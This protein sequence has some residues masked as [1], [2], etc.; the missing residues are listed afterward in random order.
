MDTELL[1]T[2][3]EVHKTSHF[4]HAADNLFLTQAAVSARIKQLEE[5]LGSR[6]FTRTRNNLQLTETGQRLLPHAQSILVAWDRAKQDVSLSGGD[7]IVLSVGAL[8]SLWDLFLAPLVEE[9][10]QQNSLSR[11]RVNALTQDVLIRRL[12]DR[13]LDVAFLYEPAKNAELTSESLGQIEL[14]LMTSMKDDVD[15]SKDIPNFVAIDWGTS[16]NIMF[17]K[18]FGNQPAILHTTVAR[19]AQSFLSSQPACA[20]LPRKLE[21]EFAVN[22]IRPVKGAPLLS[23]SIYA[24]THNDTEYDTQITNL[25]NLARPL[26]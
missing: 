15:V 4:G 19:I 25:V 14:Q 8:H 11:L 20:Y 12:L 5:S 7:D 26:F 16:F 13:T 10:Y 17:A 3:L 2:F 24:S 23:R 22:H 21:A 6:L 1:R 9:S 18:T